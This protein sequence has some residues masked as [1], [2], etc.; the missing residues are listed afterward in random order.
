MVSNECCMGSDERRMADSGRC[1]GSDSSEDERWLPVLPLSKSSMEVAASRY[2]RA[3]LIPSGLE[4]PKSISTAVCSHGSERADTCPPSRGR[5]CTPHT[6]EGCVSPGPDRR[7]TAPLCG[8]P[9]TSN[10]GGCSGG[11][12]ISRCS[13][14]S[15]A[16]R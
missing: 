5:A 12:E 10:E 9:R 13:K 6:Y 16:T 8:E 3:E 15:C 11:P 7:T 1:M 4:L 2:R 14:M